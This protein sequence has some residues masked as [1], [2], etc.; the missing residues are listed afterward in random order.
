M[1]EAEEDRGEVEVPVHIGMIPPMRS[2]LKLT[3]LPL[4]QE[5]L[6]VLPALIL[7]SVPSPQPA[8]EEEAHKMQLEATED[9]E[10]APVRPEVHRRRVQGL[11]P[12]DL[13]E[14]TTKQRLRSMEEAE[15][16]RVQSEETPHRH[17]PVSEE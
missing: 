13:P 15:E 16:E 7:S 3:L 17:W 8:A 2:L 4:V 5:G 1:V 6:Q 11:L 9:V 14:V 10:E 12:T